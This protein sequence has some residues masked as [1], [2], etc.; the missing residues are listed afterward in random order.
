[1]RKF[2]ACVRA[3][4]LQKPKRFFSPSLFIVVFLLLSISE[5]KMVCGR[6]DSGEQP[7]THYNDQVEK[8]NI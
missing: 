5:E 6:D 8:K 2:M 7:R 4:V 1:M 3:R